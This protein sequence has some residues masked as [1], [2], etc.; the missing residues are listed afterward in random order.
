MCG[1][2]VDTRQSTS[3]CAPELDGFVL[4]AGSRSLNPLSL[5]LCQKVSSMRLQRHPVDR[6]NKTL[7]MNKLS[8]GMAMQFLLAVTLVPSCPCLLLAALHPSYTSN[9]DAPAEI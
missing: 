2:N 6:I 3:G 5:S 4:C 8:D 7:M 9:M 1:G